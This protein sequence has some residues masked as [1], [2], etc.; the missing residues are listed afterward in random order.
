MDINHDYNYFTQENFSNFQFLRIP[1]EFFTKDE[2]KSLSTDAK[3]LYGI[4]LDR[5]SLSFSNGNDW[6]DKEGHVYIIY[7]IED[8][9]ECLSYGK[10]KICNMLSELESNKLIVRKRMGLGRPNRIYVLN[11][12]SKNEASV[13]AEINNS[14]LP[15]SAIPEN[16]DTEIEL[17]ETNNT[18]TIN[19]DTNKTESVNHDGTIDLYSHLSNIINVLNSNEFLSW[20][21]S[22]LEAKKMALDDILSTIYTAICN[23][24]PIKVNKMPITYDSFITKLKSLSVED[25]KNILTT[26]INKGPDNKNKMYG[27][28]LSVTYN[29]QSQNN[30]K[31]L[32]DKKLE[33][34]HYDWDKLES[35]LLS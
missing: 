32:S 2:F 23:K 28:I 10:D 6:R 19:T 15:N 9:I 34:R 33:G 31:L 14:I 3:L 7:T 25:I 4:L 8:L 35:Q 26:I 1:K 29:I 20:K 22:L 11:F 5:M 17:H 24:K 21:D 18:K 13:K 27:Y 30:I 16:R 12:S